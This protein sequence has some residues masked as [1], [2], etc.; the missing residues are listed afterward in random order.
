MRNTKKDKTKMSTDIKGIPFIA[1]SFLLASERCQEQR[2][3]EDGKIEMLMIPSIVCLAFATELYIKAI[4]ENEGNPRKGHEIKTLISS[5]SK[6]K[7]E[8]IIQNIG[9]SESDFDKKID[10]INKA[11][12]DWRYLYEKGAMTIDLSF[13][14]SILN[15]VKKIAESIK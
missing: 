8:K 13:L 7:Y 12:I 11:F 15:E 6:G 9:L 14:K 4:L 1:K 2:I 3:K 10:E 5:L